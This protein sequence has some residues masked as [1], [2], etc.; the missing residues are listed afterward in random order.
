MKVSSEITKKDLIKL[1]TTCGNS[2]FDR[3]YDESE[4]G[5]DYLM[6]TG[7]SNE[8]WL[9]KNNKA[10]LENCRKC[11]MWERCRKAEHTIMTNQGISMKLRDDITKS[12]DKEILKDI[13]KDWNKRNRKN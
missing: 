10:G 4:Y 13:E 5:D 6:H 11:P 12:I 1:A 9:E 2:S 7:M 3:I 8:E